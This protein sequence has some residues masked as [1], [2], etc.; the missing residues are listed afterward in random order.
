MNN[1]ALAVLVAVAVVAGA[2]VAGIG[3]ATRGGSKGSRVALVVDEKAGRIGP[4]VLGETRAD[5]VA[6]LGKPRSTTPTGTLVYRHL[7]VDVLNGRVIAIQT[8]DP[9][10]RTLK[11][12]GVGDALGAIRV[13][14]RKT[15][16]CEKLPE[17]ETEGGTGSSA[18]SCTVNVPAGKLLALGDP[19]DTF[20]LS[21]R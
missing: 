16:T 6:V 15:A 21:R 19:I 20:R 17:K 3:L 14:Y 7:S 1:H 12:V 5:V 2:A 11:H 9:T 13:A 4:V 10:A 18:S 8:D